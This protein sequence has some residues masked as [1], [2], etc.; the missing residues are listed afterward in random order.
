MTKLLISA[1]AAL[2]FI[3]GVLW[4]QLDSKTES[5]GRVKSELSQS[6]AAVESIRST[7]KLQRELTAIAETESQQ[8]DQY[9]EQ[10]RT[11]VA[12]DDTDSRLR[13]ELAAV[14]RSTAR[15]IANA[16]TQRLADQ[17]TIG[18]LA[19]MLESCSG[20]AGVVAGAFEE[21]RAR[22]LTCQRVYE[23]VRAAK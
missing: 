7:L 5:L 19:H 3:V 22:G 8:G 4:W 6:Q 13:Q 20:F 14:R 10:I 23:G 2:V 16:A 9:I 17:Q 21:A 1:L 12:A 18:V 11:D 15:T